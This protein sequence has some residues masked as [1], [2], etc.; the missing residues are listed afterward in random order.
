M[1]RGKAELAIGN[2]TLLERSIRVLSTVAE[3]VIVAAAPKQ[4]LPRL[5]AE[6]VVVRD[7]APT[8]GPLAAFAGALAV[9]SHSASSVYLVGCDLPFVTSEFLWLLAARLGDA[10]AVVPFFDGKRHPLVALYARRVQAKVDAILATGKRS[11]LALLDA[12]AVIPLAEVEMQPV[13]P[14]GR[15]LHNVNTPDDYA[16]ALRDVGS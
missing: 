12:I 7:A 13:G 4:Q 3:P 6:I 9:V 8:A 5:P 16:A 1:G 15:C 11:M 2:E 14:A 10:D